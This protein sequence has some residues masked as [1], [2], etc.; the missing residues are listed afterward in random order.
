V[1]A[2]PVRQGAVLALL[3]AEVAVQP[4]AE[5][6]VA[7]LPR[8]AEAAVVEL[9]RREEAVVAVQ[10]RAEAVVESQRRAEAVAACGGGGGVTAACG[11]DVCTARSLTGLTA[12]R[13]KKERNGEENPGPAR[14]GRNP[15]YAAASVF[16]LATTTPSTTEGEASGR[17]STSSGRPTLLAQRFRA[18]ADDLKRSEASRLQKLLL[19]I[20]ELRSLSPWDF[21]DIVA[22]MFER[23]GFTTD[24]AVSG[25]FATAGGFSKD[26]IAFSRT[27]PM[28]LVDE[29]SLRT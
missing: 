22:Q 27:V 10:S 26:A 29:M 28:V 19:G 20:E 11:G 21:E 4:R 23:M 18:A 3:P 25:F 15:L 6:V 7:E 17:R 5:A 9:P 8:R 14:P 13:R 24:G 16:T 12:P 2:A 1:D